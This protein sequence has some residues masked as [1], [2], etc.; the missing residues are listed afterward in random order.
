MEVLT[1]T[2][3]KWKNTYQETLPLGWWSSVCRLLE[4][5]DWDEVV[6]IGLSSQV[7][8]YVINDEEV[9]PWNSKAGNEELKVW[10][11][12]FSDETFLEEIAM[13]HPNIIS[14]PLPRLKYIMEH[15][16]DIQKI[17]QPKEYI[18]FHLTGQW[19]TD[20]YS[21]RGLAKPETGSYSELFLK[22]L[23]ISKEILPPIKRF[24]EIGGYTKEIKLK[25]SILPA[26]IPVY[27][28]LNDYYAGLL[29]MGMVKTGQM[30]DVTGTSEHLGV[31]QKQ[32]ALPTDLVSGPY[33]K[34]MVH[35]GVT[36]SAGPSIKYGLKLMKE[37]AIDMEEMLNQQ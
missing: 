10:K 31:L 15:Y 25:N 21:W 28:G 32:V 35:Y 5:M 9:I 27:V 20:V 1:K 26:G 6:A 36:A 37:V 3:E 7:G 22:E 17:S 2:V 4:Q 8:T 23:G 29:G 19:V 13:P 30:F 18:L 14:Y 12:K 11:E 24:D 33:I 16:K 34:H